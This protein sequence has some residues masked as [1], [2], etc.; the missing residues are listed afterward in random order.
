[1]KL[2]KFISSNIVLKITSLNAVV[3]TIRLLVSAGVQRLLAVTVGEAGYASIGQVRNILA[4]LT[5]TTT[6]GTFNGV[7]KYV[8]E[9]KTN[10]PELSK[11]FSTVTTFTLIGSLVS[12][13]VLFFGASHLS[14]YLFNSQAYIYIFQLLAVIAPFIAMSRVANA[15]VSGLSD[16]KKY[17]KIELISYLLATVAL[18]I[19]LFTSELKGVIIAIAFA[20][21]IQLIVLGFVFGKTLKTYVKFKSLGFQLFYKNKLLAFTLMSFISTFLLN[22]IELNIRTL[23]AEEINI[24]E[25]GYWTAITFISKNYMVFATGLFTLYVLPKFASIHS[26]YEFKNEVFNIYKTILPIFG[27]GMLLVYVLRDYI[28]QFIYPDFTGMEPLFK[29][30][31]LGD[32]IRLGALVLSHQ[33]LAKRLV[34][35]FVITE[36]ASLALFFV[37][38]KVFIQY[39]GTEGIVIAHFVRYILY[40]IMVCFVIKIYFSNQKNNS[41]DGKNM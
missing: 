40:F 39:Y 35:S 16:Y 3:I 21:V 34:K 9:F 29:W 33:F 30:Q 19:G 4:M 13:V 12:A 23:V 2:P 22:Y 5:S 8:A 31:L 24:N 20:P 26:K 36:I 14:E 28:I 11:V 32:F 27:L 6:L 7:V 1:M 25:A 37:L 41:T 17:A 15:V 38:S 10:Q 18:V